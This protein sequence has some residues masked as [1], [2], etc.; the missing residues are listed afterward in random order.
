MDAAP[1][2]VDAAPDAA[3]PPWAECEDE[4]DEPPLTEVEIKIRELEEPHVAKVAF[5]TS[6]ECVTELPPT[7]A[8]YFRLVHEFENED[9]DEDRRVVPIPFMKTKAD[10]ERVVEFVVKYRDEPFAPKKPVVDDDLSHHRFPAWAVEW[11]SKI[12]PNQF[13]Y[14]M[15]EANDL[16][17]DE[18]LRAAT[19]ALACFIRAQ[20]Q[21]E[22]ERIFLGPVLKDDGT[23]M[24]EE[25]ERE[26]LKAENDWEN[27]DCTPSA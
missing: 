13:I 10:F 3:R 19:G 7:I 8:S 2:P 16:Q 21:E 20:P 25:E 18:L 11:F 1:G 12:D 15:E 14:I 26:L 22:I 6:D 4:D 9:D 27:E 24:T 23:Y 5:V 17:C